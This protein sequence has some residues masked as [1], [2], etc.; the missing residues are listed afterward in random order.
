VNFALGIEENLTFLPGG[1]PFCEARAKRLQRKARPAGKRPK[2]N[3]ITQK[4]FK[5]QI[6]QVIIKTVHF[7][8]RTLSGYTIISH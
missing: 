3:E 4:L 6:I 8:I 2:I 7:C 5:N 1:E